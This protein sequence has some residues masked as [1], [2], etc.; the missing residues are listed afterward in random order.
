MK[1][2]VCFVCLTFLASM[3]CAMGQID[4]V[5]IKDTISFDDYDMKIDLG[6]V[7]IS[8]PKETGTLMSRPV[9]STKIGSDEMESKHIT[10]LVGVSN[11]VPNFFMPDYGSRLTS[12]IYI[13]G[14]GSRINTPAVGLYVDDIPYVDKSAFNFNFY[15]IDR[16]EVLRGPQGTLYGRNAMGGLIKIYTKDPSREV[17]PWQRL[18]KT[19]VKV[20]YATQDNHR[21][22]SFNHYRNINNKFAFTLGGYYEGSDGFFRHSLTGSKVDDIQA[23]GGRFRGIY[24]PNSKLKFDLTASYDYSDEG[25]YP[26]YL[27]EDNKEL[28]VRS[29]ELGV[30][31]SYIG[32]ITNN[33]ENRYRRGLFNAGLN[34]DYRFNDML[35]HSATGYQNLNDRMF[36][37][38]DFTGANFY[39]IEQKQK[40]NVVSEEV[41]L[42]NDRDVLSGFA[43]RLMDEFQYDWLVGASGFYQWLNTDGPVTF[44][45]E[46]IKS[47]I[48]DNVN[49]IFTEVRKQ[50]P[51]MPEMGI[52]IKPEEFVVGSDM[53]TPLL[54]AGLFHQSSFSYGPWS[55]TAGIR[56]DYEKLKLEYN[57]GTSV[58][59]DFVIKMM[60]RPF[61]L[62]A[63]PAFM[64]SLER[65]YVQWLPKLSLKYSFN[66]LFDDATLRNNFVYASV[67]KGYRSG[68]YNVQMFSDLIQ[69]E[70]RNLM[71]DDVNKASSGMMSKF[72]DID[73]IKVPVDIN[74]VIYDPEYSWNYEVG[75][76]I[77]TSRLNLQA[78]VFYIRTYDQQIARFA[79]SGLGRMMVNA[80]KS[81]SIGA[82]LSASYW[83]KNLMLSANY[84][85]TRATFREYNDGTNDYSDNYVPFVPMHN[86]NIGAEY[87]LRYDRSDVSKTVSIG[88]DVTGQGR[89][90]WT[91]KND[92]SQDFYALLNAHVTVGLSEKLSINLW[93]K[94]LT[95]S[96]F[97]TF[98][99]ESAGRLYEQRNK[100]C[101][102]GVDVRLSF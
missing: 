5:N 56:M 79:A 59:Y 35:L 42:R 91:E 89:I 78:A 63:S 72:V 86:G 19:D 6:E 99:F 24:E 29:E 23:G 64:G 15:D 26:Y 20:G 14:V 73:K 76:H 65:D 100:P 85:Y 41:T 57:S 32:K 83:L 7:L 4:D 17:M 60:P 40:L 37:D 43:S 21:D 80:G 90:Y 74:S 28:G 2:K 9:A 77:Q 54:S 47:M 18:G 71:I 55:L 25:G 8:S 81:Q 97:N 93:G 87:K 34:V 67:S 66:S 75:T 44:Y 36:I 52:D 101:Q 62:N 68:G 94:N 11:Q 46:G 92:A 70:M 1:K 95:S 88:A 98:Y 30:D 16:V 84:G 3:T 12:A 96:R 51:K 50:M 102:F 53:D 61:S 31:P 69:G 58:D 27:S 45:D 13:R 39:T 82:E 38:Q 33:H 10:S 48:E 49:N 22:V